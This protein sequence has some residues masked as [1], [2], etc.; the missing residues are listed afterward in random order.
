MNEQSDF[1]ALK[2]RIKELEKRTKELEK[3][4]S[5]LKF[6]KLSLENMPGIMFSI[7]NKD[8][9]YEAVNKEYSGAFNINTDKIIGKHATE[10]LGDKLF[11]TLAKANYDKSLNGECVNH[12]GWICFPNSKKKFLNI[13]YYPLYNG[14]DIIAVAVLAHDITTIKQSE[15]LLLEGQAQQQYRTIIQTAIDGF[16]LSDPQGRLLEVN[17]SFCK[18]LGYRCEELLQLNISDLHASQT[19]RETTRMLT[20][21]RPKGKCRFETKYQCKDGTFIDVEINI[22]YLDIKNGIFVSFVRN[23]T[24]KNQIRSMLKDSERR[25]RNLFEGAPMM[26]VILRYQKNIQVISD[27]NKYFVKTLGYKRSDVIGKPISFFYTKSSQEQLLLE[28]KYRGRNKEH[29]TISEQELVRHD[30]DIV[31]TLIQTLSEY[32]I[33]GNVIGTRAMFIDTSRQKKAEQQLKESYKLLLTIVDGI[34]DPLLMVDKKMDIIMM[35]TAAKAYF[36]NENE[37]CLGKKCYQV[38]KKRHRPCKGCKVPL[39]VSNGQKKT[40]ERKSIMDPGRLEKISIY[41]VW[42]DGKMWSVII[43][44]T[45]ITK[46]KQIENEL[47]QA[48]K[49]ISLG[50]LV[51]GIAHEINNPN[52][53]IML[54]IPIVW[55]AWESVVPVIESYYKRNGDFCIAGIPYCEIRDE[56]PLLLSGI[57][58]G[59]ER[60]RQIVQELKNF[61]RNDNTNINQLL[62]INDVIKK[63]IRLTK[64][65]IKEKTDHFKV[66]YSSNLPIIKGDPQ[67]IEQVFINLIENAC[68]SLPNKKKKIFIS[69]FFENTTGYVVVRI[70]DEG[71]GIHPKILNRIMEPFFTTKRSKGGTGLGLAICSRI[72]ELHGGKIEV[73]SVIDKGSI[74]KILLPVQ[75]GKDPA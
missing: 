63:T 24:K 7:I 13:H 10:I 75:C 26:Y 57:S 39:A 64:N 73:N 22:Q 65:M 23:I 52:N 53:L 48:D 61:V 74:F 36:K 70:Q 1:K 54:N 69:S 45:D 29:F 37:S 8:Y 19:A 4:N 31:N 34:S 28:E 60:I 55:K 71:R 2:K 62:N 51:S 14:V 11:H 38:L 30:G 27:C 59:T 3:E 47:I 6:F 21:I 17:A 25:Y 15:E 42:K 35:N 50:V 32:D 12:S 72:V 18:M 56:I 41:P 5:Q 58:E 43:R 66:D 46:T 16:H 20:Q 44:L 67:K 9:C 49:M 40:F 33:N 68:Q